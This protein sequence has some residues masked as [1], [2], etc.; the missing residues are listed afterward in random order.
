MQISETD[1][2]IWFNS[3]SDDY[4][5]LKTSYGIRSLSCPV[6]EFGRYLFPEESV[7]AARDYLRV[8][9]SFFHR[10]WIQNAIKDFDNQFPTKKYCTKEEILKKIPSWK[11][12]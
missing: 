8:G 1:F 7:A 4:L 2:L 12:K 5:F 6:S 10:K 9:F 11:Q 3:L